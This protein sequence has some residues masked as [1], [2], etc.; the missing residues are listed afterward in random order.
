MERDKTLPESYYK[1]MDEKLSAR[2]SRPV[3]YHLGVTVYTIGP[4]GKRT[5]VWDKPVVPQITK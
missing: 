5:I 2:V 1:I 4:D 3:K